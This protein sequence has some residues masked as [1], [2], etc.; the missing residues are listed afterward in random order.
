MSTEDKPVAQKLD[1]DKNMSSENKNMPLT[2][3][4]RFTLTVFA[5]L[6]FVVGIQSMNQV[7]LTNHS[8]LFSEVTLTNPDFLLGLIIVSVGVYGIIFS[9]R[10]N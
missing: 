1:R 8:S 10:S 6:V 7:V 3:K 2:K 9:Y 4:Q 5:T